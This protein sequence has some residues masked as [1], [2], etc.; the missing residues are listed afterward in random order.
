MEAILQNIHRN[1]TIKQ[2]SGQKVSLRSVVDGVQ[3]MK[4]ISSVFSGVFTKGRI[5]RKGC[6]LET[7]FQQVEPAC[8]YVSPSFCHRKS[9]YIHTNYQNSCVA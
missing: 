2:D 1:E 4:R 9:A 8:P 5:V 3:L 6:A 7:S